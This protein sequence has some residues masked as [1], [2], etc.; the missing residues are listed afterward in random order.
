MR[1]TF[2][3]FFAS[4]WSRPDPVLEH[5]AVAGELLVAKVRLGLSSVLL[6]IPVIDGLFFP[7]PRSEAI[8]GVSL[9]SATVLVS[10]TVYTLIAR[11][12]NPTWLGFFTSSLDVTLVSGALALFLSPT[13]LTPR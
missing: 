1:F 9:T 3:N 5:A 2:R 4:L 6:L 8:V 13:S 12:Y 10:L 11:E 7:T